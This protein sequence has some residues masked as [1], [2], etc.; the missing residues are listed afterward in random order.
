MPIFQYQALT[1]AGRQKKGIIDADSPRQAREKLRLEH[2]HVTAMGL[3]PDKETHGRAKKDKL[4]AI[5]PFAHRLS[6]RELAIVTRQ[7]STLL[8]SGIHLS[9]A[10]TAIV[11]QSANPRVERIFRDLREKITGGVS[12]AEALA[13]HPRYFSDLYVNMV[14]AGEASGNLDEV[15]HRLADYLQKQASI[16]GKIATA[17]TYPAFMIL[18][19][20]GVV[21]FLMSSTVPKISQLLIQRGL[22]LPRSTEVLIAVSHFFRDFWWLLAMAVV[23]GAVAYRLFTA[24]KRGRYV[25]DKYWLRIP[26]VGPVLRKQAI[27]RFS[28]TLSTLLK[29]GLPALD[30]L[31]IVAKVVGNSVVGEVINEVHGR[32]LEGTDISSPIK[33]SKVFP[34]MVGYMV[35]VGEQSG[36]LE[37]V[38]DRMS[39]AYDEEIDLA[40]QRMTSLLEPII[41]IVL[42]VFVGFIIA[43]ILL[44][45]I[46]FTNV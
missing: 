15:L 2:L 45:L 8:R 11:E 34:P 3:M 27:S 25:A 5:R 9:D 26:L 43:S 20:V 29:S 42:A 30:S 36:Q 12:L 17:L 14:R 22:A 39:E 19:G 31:R 37:D 32:I 13:N 46:R 38:L 41:I 23:G 16:R 28:V 40:V 10:I 44:P 33:R 21:T 35:A 24:S 1:T 18:F 7:L 4:A 6:V